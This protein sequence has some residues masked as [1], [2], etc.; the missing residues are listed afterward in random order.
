MITQH[1]T[2]YST[3]G[4]TTRGMLK[5]EGTIRQVHLPWFSARAAQQDR[6]LLIR[7][8]ASLKNDD[9]VYRGTAYKPF[10]MANYNS[11]RHTL[12]ESIIIPK[13]RASLSVREHWVLRPWGSRSLHVHPGY[14]THHEQAQTKIWLGSSP[15]HP[16][17]SR[18]KLFPVWT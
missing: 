18:L 5:A 3:T 4:G 8:R 9:S 2:Y 1:K 17:Q 15:I 11:S 7:S 12:W 16:R 14:C 13:W 6:S 10:A